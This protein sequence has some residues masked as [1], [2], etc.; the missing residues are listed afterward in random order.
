MTFS[1]SGKMLKNRCKTGGQK[2]I[3]S[4][5]LRTL[6]GQGS[7]VSAFFDVLARCQKT[8]V[9]L[10]VPKS[11]KNLKKSA[12]VRPRVDFVAPGQRRLV[13]FWPGGSQG[14]PRA[15]GLVKKLG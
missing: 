13:H 10:I 11:I 12:L 4:T 6:G 7:I 2:L 14:P 1:H 9:F 15:R 8:H 3:F 5:L